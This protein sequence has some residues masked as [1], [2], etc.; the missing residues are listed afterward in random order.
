VQTTSL[1]DRFMAKVSP[2]PNSGC[3]L[4]MGS[5]D[6]GGRAKFRSP[7]STVAAH[8]AYTLFCGIIPDG[9]QVLHR[10]DM[11]ACVNPDHLFLGT[12]QDNMADRNAK[13]RHAHGERH[14][15]AKLTEADVRAIRASTENDVVLAKRYGRGVSTIH[16]ARS[17]RHY[18]KHL[19]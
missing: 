18:W 11:P 6:W 9:V 13:K 4:W 3:W 10:C 19:K 7:D 12:L 8:A 17:G 15:K 14:G 2:E 16:A 5:C 1:M